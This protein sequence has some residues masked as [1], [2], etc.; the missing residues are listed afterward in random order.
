MCITDEKIALIV[1]GNT[2][3]FKELYDFLFPSLA[4]FS[5]RLVQDKEEASDIVQEA[6][7][8]YW[9]R[10]AEFRKLDNIKAFLYTVIKHLGLNYLRS[11]KVHL[12][13]I[14]RNENKSES[15]I[16]NLIIEEE[17]LSIIASALENLPPK[18]KDIVLLSLEGVK[19]SE[20]AERCNISVNTVKTLKLRAYKKLRIHLRNHVFVW[21]L[22]YILLF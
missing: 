20:I 21:L 19:N 14:Q 6:L 10:R 2:A 5:Y 15:Y 16:K 11:K 3:A 13:Y 18:T 22:L 17:T 12:K 8:A 7:I 1:D 4:A 9:N